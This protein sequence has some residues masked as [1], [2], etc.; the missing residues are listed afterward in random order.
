[1]KVPG[2]GRTLNTINNPK[3][4]AAN[5]GTSAVSVGGG[6]AGSNNSF[7]GLMLPTAAAA[8]TAT[9]TSSSAS[10]AAGGSIRYAPG[11][12]PL[13]PV[14]HKGPITT[15]NPNVKLQDLGNNILK[16]QRPGQGAAPAGGPKVVMPTGDANNPIQV[17][18]LW[19]F[20][21]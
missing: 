17:S 12:L 11:G 21:S 18:D 10:S 4:G 6:N 7:G 14:G 1:M 13:G 5:G 8:P 16:I 9:A 20:I 2:G 15:K 3:G 19:S